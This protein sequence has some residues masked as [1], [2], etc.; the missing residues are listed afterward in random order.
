[1]NSTFHPLVELY[2]E[3]LNPVNKYKFDRGCGGH[4]FGLASL[5]EQI[6]PELLLFYTTI[7]PENRQLFKEAYIKHIRVITNNHIGGPDDWAEAYLRKNNLTLEELFADKLRTSNLPHDQIP[8]IFIYTYQDLREKGVDH[9]MLDLHVAFFFLI[10]NYYTEKFI[11]FFENL[12]VYGP[13]ATKSTP[14]LSKTQ[15][16]TA[17]PSSYQLKSYSSKLNCITN[18]L[19]SMN[20]LGLITDD[21]DIKDFR[22]IFN[23]TLPSIPITWSGTI[24]EL[25]YFVKCLHDLELITD[26]KKDKWKITSQL[27]VDSKGDHFVWTKFRGLKTPASH[28]NIETAVLHLK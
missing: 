5:L 13:P 3:E 8:G 26:L 18:L 9:V 15:A 11:E 22:K 25:Y 10:T 12:P 24:T 6:E 2:L 1:M 27:F 4:Y 7:P 16:H 21:T 17:L 14:A 20:D 28:K 19:D 23:N